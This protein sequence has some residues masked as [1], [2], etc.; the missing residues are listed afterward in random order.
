MKQSD[1]IFRLGRRIRVLRK[2]DGL[3]QERLA[4]QSGISLKYVQKLEG[5]DPQ[6]PSLVVLHKIANG[7]GIPLWKLLKFEEKE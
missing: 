2:K 1:V 3:T 5:K 7:F 6:N 4:G